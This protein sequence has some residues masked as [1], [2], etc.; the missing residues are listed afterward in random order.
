MTGKIKTT[1]TAYEVDPEDI[2]KGLER[3]Y[4]KFFTDNKIKNISFYE[5]RK[6]GLMLKKILVTPEIML[7]MKWKISDRSITYRRDRVYF[8]DIRVE[9]IEIPKEE[10]TKLID[11]VEKHSQLEVLSTT[12]YLQKLTI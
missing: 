10:I 8:R 6:K 12:Q 9:T 1:I 5:L 11:Y 4:L 2:V 7:D 3:V